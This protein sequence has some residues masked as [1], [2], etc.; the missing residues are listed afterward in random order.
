VLTPLFEDEDLLFLDKPAGMPTVSLQKEGS[1]RSLQDEF[2][3]R[4][5]RSALGKDRDY[6][7]LNR[8][9][10]D[11]TGIVVVAKNPQTFDLLRENWTL[12]VK[13]IYRAVVSSKL[14][15][16][17]VQFDLPREG[18]TIEL[19]VGHSPKSK[20]KM[21]VKPLVGRKK[22]RGEWQPAIT[23]I[24]KIHA[25]S[26]AKQK[27]DLELQIKTGVRHQIRAHLSALGWPILGDALYGGEQASRLFLHAWKISLEKPNKQKLNVEAPLPSDWLTI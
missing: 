20:K 6:G 3:A 7:F 24:R 14:S 10:N 23:T 21:L 11:T 8:L 18:M 22:V 19:P 15:E 5:E 25:Q 27:L 9:D 26:Q 1:K 17:G 13:K 12:S 4:F 16:D 2:L